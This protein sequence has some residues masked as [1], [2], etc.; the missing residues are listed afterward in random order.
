MTGCK[1]RPLADENLSC[2]FM[3][4]NI[5][6]LCADQQCRCV[7]VLLCLLGRENI[8]F[9]RCGLR[10]FPLGYSVMYLINF[11]FMF[12]ISW[13]IPVNLLGILHSLLNNSWS[14]SVVVGYTRICCRK[15]DPFHGLRVGSCLTLRNELSEETH[16]QETLLGRGVLTESRRARKPRGTALPR[17]SQSQVFWWWGYLPV[18]LLPVTSPGP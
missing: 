16:E 7:Y 9:Q 3:F 17:G 2:V 14:H 13:T 15:G 5:L 1:S 12:I 10:K 8:F 6:S 18:W 4:L 11:P